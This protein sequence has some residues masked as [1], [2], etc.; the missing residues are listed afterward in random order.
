MSKTGS[1]QKG[2]FLDKASDRAQRGTP[3]LG[4]YWKSSHTC[5]IR[6]NMTCYSLE[7][8][9][10]LPH[11]DESRMGTI[12]AAQEFSVPIRKP[13]AGAASEGAY[14]AL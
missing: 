6:M 3:G 8:I 14:I 7:I 2:D 10:S 5:K 13:W 12:S 1:L 11:E 9:G 4:M